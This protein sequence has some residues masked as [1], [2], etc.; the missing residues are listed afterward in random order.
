MKYTNESWNKLSREEK[1][2]ALIRFE[3]P[4]YIYNPIKIDKERIFK[5]ESN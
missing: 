3:A 4:D 5:Q 2:L 1:Q